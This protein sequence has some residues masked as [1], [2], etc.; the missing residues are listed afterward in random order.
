M[1][2]ELYVILPLLG[3]FVGVSAGLLGVGGGGI[4]VPV[5]T[6][7]FTYMGFAVSE[8]VHLALGTSMATIIATSFSSARAHHQKG[9]V[10]WL[11]WRAMTP[12]VLLG[13][14]LATFVVA[15]LPAQFL[16]SFFACFMALVAFQMWRPFRPSS[17]LSPAPLELFGAG[18][19]IGAISAMVSIGGGSLTVPYLT[20]RNHV[21]T[22][23]VATSSALGLPIAITGTL[24]YL[25]NGWHHTDLS[26]G[27][28]GYIYLPAVIILSVFSM[29][30]VPYGTR[31]A[32]RLPV[33]VLRKVFAFL[34]VIISSHM[35]WQV[36][37]KS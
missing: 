9:S 35:F 28:L 20:W 14:F 18:A 2:L 22:Q 3:L 1:T 6:A 10:V 17:H 30:A 23:A 15:L 36:V 19:G 21:M 7:V 27:M 11:T 16:A 34:L 25:L 31:L 26:Q 29:L 12:G 13:T 8:V 37:A 33:S 24:G 5:L 32:Y 4:M